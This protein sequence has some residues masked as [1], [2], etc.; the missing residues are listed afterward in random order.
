MRLWI[1]T[2]LLLIHTHSLSEICRFNP[3]LKSAEV[4]PLVVGQSQIEA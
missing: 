3:R 1:H 2:E 4:I